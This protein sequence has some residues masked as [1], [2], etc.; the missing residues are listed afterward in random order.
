MA[1]GVRPR[2][3]NYRDRLGWLRQQRIHEALEAVEF[4]NAELQEGDGEAVGI[5]APYD[6]LDGH[7]PLPVGRRELK[8]DFGSHRGAGVGRR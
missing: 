7:G 3:S 6:P 2:S 5:H 4:V 1:T 8:L